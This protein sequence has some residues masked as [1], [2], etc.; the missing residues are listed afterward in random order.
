MTTKPELSKEDLIFVLTTLKDEWDRLIP[1][2]KSSGLTEEEA[3]AKF[4]EEFNK[5]LNRHHKKS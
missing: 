2:Y 5:F 3:I 1:L 4:G